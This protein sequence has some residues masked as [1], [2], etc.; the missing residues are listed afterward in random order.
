[1]SRYKVS[2]PWTIDDESYAPFVVE[3]ADI[4]DTRN[5]DVFRDGAIR[6]VVAGKPALRGK[7]GTV[8]FYGECAWSD[9]RR[10][11]GDLALAERY[12]D[13]YVRTT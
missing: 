8:P 10:L 1:M 5:G 3:S 2:S 9:A 6:V 12:G 7:G 13:R 11:A 4:V